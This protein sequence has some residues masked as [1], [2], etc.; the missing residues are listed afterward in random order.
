MPALPYSFSGQAI[1]LR[2]GPGTT[3]YL[4]VSD[5][6]M[7]IQNATFVMPSQEMLK[8]KWKEEKKK[9]GESFSC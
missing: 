5:S 2:E 7:D 8:I 6:E 4:T 9:K 1:V 3:L